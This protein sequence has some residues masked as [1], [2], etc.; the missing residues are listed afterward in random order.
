ME[1]KIKMVDFKVYFAIYETEPDI[2]YDDQKVEKFILFDGLFKSVEEAATFVEMRVN[3]N[4]LS[5]S[6]VKNIRIYEGK[7]DLELIL[8]GRL[9]LQWHSNKP[10]VTCKH[11]IEHVEEE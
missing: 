1:H 4:N 2:E 3:S 9:K 8:S 5:P 7:T 6:E 10:I 11:A